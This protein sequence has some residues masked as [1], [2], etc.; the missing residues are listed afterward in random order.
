M[1]KI[2]FKGRVE[3]PFDSAKLPPSR[4]ISVSSE[5]KYGGGNDSLT[6]SLG[7][8]SHNRKRQHEMMLA[9]P[10]NASHPFTSSVQQLMSAQNNQVPSR[11]TLPPTTHSP[12]LFSS[13]KTLTNCAICTS[14]A[15]VNS[16]VSLLYDIRA[17]FSIPALKISR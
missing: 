14:Y 10:T 3:W 6:P 1:L 11:R 15:S 13:S 7:G 16:S 5:Y 2:R 9:R 17:W 12:V 8:Y 4:L